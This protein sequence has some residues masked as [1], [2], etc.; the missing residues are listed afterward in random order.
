VQPIYDSLLVEVDAE[1]VK[2]AEARAQERDVA[3]YWDSLLGT[4]ES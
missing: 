3:W 2:T 1:M 4:A